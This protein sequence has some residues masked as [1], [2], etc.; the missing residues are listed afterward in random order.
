MNALLRLLYSS[1]HMLN[2]MEQGS[3]MSCPRPSNNSEAKLVKSC[4][5]SKYLLYHL[6]HLTSEC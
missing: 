3:K 2:S 1:F 5:I 6:L 4:Y